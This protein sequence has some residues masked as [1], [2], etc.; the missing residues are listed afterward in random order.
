MPANVSAQILSQEPAEDIHFIMLKT[1]RVEITLN[2][3]SLQ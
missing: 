2:T 1:E 3:F